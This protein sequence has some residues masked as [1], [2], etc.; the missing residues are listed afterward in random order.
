M[1][2]S[3]QIELNIIRKIKQAKEE[4]DKMFCTGI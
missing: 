4:F 2:L 3:W 1:K